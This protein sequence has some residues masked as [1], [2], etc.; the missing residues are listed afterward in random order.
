MANA[1]RNY[2]MLSVWPEYYDVCVEDGFTLLGVGRPQR[3]R[4]Q[5][6]EVGDRAL[7]YVTER[8]AFG[9]TVTITGTYFEDRNPHWPSPDPKE[10]LA[11]R[12]ET[13]P[14]ATSDEERAVDARLIAPRLEYVKRW[15]PEDWPLAFQGL[16]HLI[17]KRDFLLIEREIRRGRVRPEIALV[18]DPRHGPRAREAQFTGRL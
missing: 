3:R 9:A 2:W 13:K 14:D 10:P 7:L 12:V 18:P 16:L 8:M 15:P 1:P 6:M 17:P 11:W 5:R 4:A